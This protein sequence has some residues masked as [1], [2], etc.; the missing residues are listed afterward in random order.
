MRYITPR[1]LLLFTLLIGWL[2]DHWSKADNYSL[3]CMFVCRDFAYVSVDAARGSH[4]C[5][6]FRSDTAACQISDTLHSVTDTRHKRVRSLTLF[7]ASLTHL[8]SVPDLRHSSLRHWSNFSAAY[9]HQPD[10]DVDETPSRSDGHHQCDV[11]NWCWRSETE[12]F[13]EPYHW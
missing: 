8:I 4:T 5:H 10:R 13:A 9:I 6:V 3:T 1:T 12:Q 2:I 7:T 11:T